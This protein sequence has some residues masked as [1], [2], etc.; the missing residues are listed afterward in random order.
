MTVLSF[1]HLREQNLTRCRRWQPE[2]ARTWTFDDWLLALGGE[3]G[4]A[5]NIV[6][7]LNRD[8]DGHAGNTRSRYELIVDLGGELADV[9]IYLDICIGWDQ[10]ELLLANSYTGLIKGEQ[11]G[12]FDRF[13]KSRKEPAT[14][15]PSRLGNR[16]LA[17]TG[18][19][20]YGP[21]GIAWA[22]DV[23]RCTDRLAEHF[24]ID[25][26]A[27]VVTKFNA[28]SERFGFPERLAA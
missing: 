28:T 8:Q 2:G 21:A 17:A 14:D 25:L 11:G 22:N 20:L 3:V 19:Q 15:T 4:E 12:N 23:L 26:G 18:D 6:K 16:L 13:R 1:A 27:V 9:A 7:K 10:P 5:L 24:G